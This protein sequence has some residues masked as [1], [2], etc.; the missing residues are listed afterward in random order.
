MDISKEDFAAALKND[1]VSD[2]F[3]C[4]T[5]LRDRQVSAAAEIYAR[6][7]ADGE[8]HAVVYVSMLKIMDADVA[9]QACVEAGN[10][11]WRETWST[12]HGHAA[13]GESRTETALRLA[14]LTRINY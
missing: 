5:P 8:K 13:Y 6:A 10:L 12:S 2:L 4:V 7:R 11:A 9:D 3:G 14:G 1:P